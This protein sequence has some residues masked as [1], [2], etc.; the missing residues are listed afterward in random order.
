MSPTSH[1]CAM[2]FARQKP[3]RMLGRLPALYLV[4]LGYTIWCVLVFWMVSGAMRHQD[5]A[6]YINGAIE[7]AKGEISPWHADLF[8]YDKEFG[9]YW[10]LAS[11][12]RASG[13]RSVVLV[14]NLLQAIGFAVTFGIVL[15]YRLREVPASLILPFALCPALVLGVPFMGTAMISLTFLLLGFSVM[16]RG[17]PLRQGVACLLIGVA[18]A[19]RG[20]VILAVPALVLSQ[21][22]RK[23]FMGFFN[24]PIAGIALASV[25]PPVL[26]Q[27]WRSGQSDGG[28]LEILQSTHAGISVIAGFV[29]FGLGVPVLILLALPSSLFFAA[30]VRKRSW[31]LYY[32]VRG[33]SPLIPL[34]FYIYQLATPQ[35]F[36]LTLACYVFT[37]SDKRALL[38]FWWLRRYSVPER[39][40]STA[41]GLAIVAPWIVGVK[42]PSLKGIYPTFS[43]AQQFPTS[44]GH[45][46]MGAYAAFAYFMGRPNFAL[47]H[48][49]KIFAA[50]KNAQYDTCDG[51]VPVLS[52]PMSGYIELAVRLDNLSP[53]IVF[54]PQEVHC[55]F[56]YA[57]A[58]SLL[59][60]IPKGAVSYDTR[61]LRYASQNL[62]RYASPVSSVDGQTIL[63]VGRSVT[64]MGVLLEALRD[65][66]PGREFEFEVQTGKSESV[67]RRSGK[68]G[69]AIFAMST[70]ECGIIPD[71][72]N[73]AEIFHVNGKSLYFWTN[74]VPHSD[75]V[76]E[77]TCD[78]V[79]LTGRATPIFPRWMGR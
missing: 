43:L 53:E 61:V 22:S 51:R 74:S 4:V 29:I 64:D 44:H 16:R 21:F 46:P 75:G 50:A 57:D 11:V 66:F 23:Q 47:D 18:S 76:V 28:I 58:R 67:L 34:G 38:A 25:L 24:A 42:A 20:D 60:L 59:R 69:G 13:F 73:P 39:L 62:I 19:C 6:A 79:A 55:G 68:V 37:I 3:Q 30:A 10:L 56:A 65:R 48:N 63:K 49:Q 26:G 40:I 77:L 52:T 45:F 1:G 33:I 71:S 9:S 35:H 54:D 14:T 31:R 5:Q 7:L 8:E 36:L 72:L 2:T 17:E 32:A 12:L 78:A 70:G 41:L 15:I 27:F